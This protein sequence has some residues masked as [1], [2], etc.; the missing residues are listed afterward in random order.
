[1][2]GA[3][4]DPIARR[5]RA[6][7]RFF[8]MVM[9]R[10]MRGSFRAVRLARPG[11]PPLPPGRPV[12]I[13]TNHP[14][15]WDPAF[16]M[17]LAPRLFAGHQHYAPIE[18]AMLERYKFFRHLGFFGIEE[19]RAG[20]AGFLRTSRAVLA[21]PRRML[22]ITAQGRFAD[23]RERPLGLRPGVGHLMAALPGA[24]ALPLAV[25]YPF[26]SEKRPEAL[27][28]FGAPL[29][30]GGS[31]QE[32][33]TWIESGLTATCDRLGDLAQA[34]DPRAFQEVLRGR[35]GVGGVYGI[36]QR[37]RSALR[38]ERHVPDHLSDLGAGRS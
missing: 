38:G 6:L 10:Q 30:G 16:C 7:V 17:V 37:G 5:S 12:V 13:V 23:P 1:M 36:W 4:P 34:R 35:R 33:S 11:V 26:W 14:S 21:D 28:L 2:R 29:A 27:A 8:E 15:W 9:A 19:G 20:A 3:A 32:W 25:E 22:W 24:V 31:A 18:A